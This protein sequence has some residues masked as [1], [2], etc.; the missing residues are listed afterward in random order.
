MTPI[1]SVVLAATVF[2]VGICGPESLA[3][4]RPGERNVPE[5]FTGRATAIEDAV[6]HADLIVVG[7]ITN[8]GV[9]SPGAPGQAY[10][11]NAVIL[12]ERIIRDTTVEPG[13]PAVKVGQ[14]LRVAYTVQTIPAASAEKAAPAQERL[15]FVVQKRKGDAPSITKILRADQSAIDQIEKLVKAK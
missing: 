14:P 2:A 1:L 8:T 4:Q 13:E 10:H 6:A 5:Q 9:V 7:R 11:E 12:V 15:I 3:S